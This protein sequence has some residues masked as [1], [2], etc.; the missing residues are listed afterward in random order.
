[1]N[2]RTA[3]LARW[4]LWLLIS[5]GAALW[6]SGGLWLLLHH[7]GQVAGEFGPQTSPYEPWLLR[8]HGLALIPALLGIGGLLVAHMPKGW[9]YPHQR[10]AGSVLAALLLALTLTGYLLYYA[11]AEGL[12]SWSSIIHWGLGLATPLI[13]IW[14]YQGKIKKRKTAEP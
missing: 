10:L 12:R 11:S 4:Q 8:L 3:K 14:H 13:F 9:A 2:N 7:Y 5:S 1:M 6:L